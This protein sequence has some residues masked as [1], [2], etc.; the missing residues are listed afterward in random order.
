MRKREKWATSLHQ[1]AAL[2]SSFIKN[3]RTVAGIVAFRRPSGGLLSFA[4]IEVCFLKESFEFEKNL[5]FFLLYLIIYNE[6]VW[7]K[8][9]DI[10]K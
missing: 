6:L 7:S 5:T 3:P 10:E 1:A 4:P 9:V 8:Y 2:P